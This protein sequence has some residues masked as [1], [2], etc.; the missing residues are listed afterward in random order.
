MNSRRIAGR[1]LAVL[2]VSATLLGQA[3]PDLSGVWTLDPGRTSAVPSGGGGGSN[4][5]Q[6]GALG[7]GPPPESLKITQTPTQ[8]TIEEH[9]GETA[10][11]I[12][13]SF[14]GR[15][16]RNIVVAGRGTGGTSEAVSVWQNRRLET[17]LTMPPAAG[18]PEIV[19]YRDVRYLDATG[20]L[21][22]EIS[23]MDHPNMRRN[24]YTKGR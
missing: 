10:A 5:G 6:G 13:Y 4:G 15:P 8:L 18:L 17:I 19:R 3:P 23:W 14:D 9:R 7:I 11:R 20:A 16:S 21:V 2:V 24:V 1:A 12:V 22:V